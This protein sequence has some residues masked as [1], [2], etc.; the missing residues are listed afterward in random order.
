[1]HR[2]A[3]GRHA[4]GSAGD[5]GRILPGWATGLRFAPAGIFRAR[6]VNRGGAVFADLPWWLVRTTATMHYSVRLPCCAC[7]LGGPGHGLYL[8]F[9]ARTRFPMVNRNLLR[10]YDLPEQDLQN[11]LE[12]AFN[13]EET[14]TDLESW[15]P[16]EEQ[17][18]EVNKIVTG[19]VLQVL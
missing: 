9:C 10:Q 14:G 15:L 11:E 3:A 12:A 7:Y 5:A 8:F 18:F 17:Q 16:P 4:P 1:R 19:R 2:R 13:Q 6:I